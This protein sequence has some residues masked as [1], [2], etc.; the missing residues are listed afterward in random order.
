[1]TIE[2]LKTKMGM[3]IL[4]AVFSMNAIYAFNDYGIATNKLYNDIWGYNTPCVYAT[5]GMDG[6]RESVDIY[7]FKLE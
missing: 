7:R 4:L 1:M 5:T 2:N 6:I 3:A